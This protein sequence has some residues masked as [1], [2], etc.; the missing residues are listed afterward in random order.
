MSVESACR[1]CVVP[2]MT[3]IIAGVSLPRVP[4]GGYCSQVFEIG[5]KIGAIFQFFS[6]SVA[7]ES[8]MHNPQ[9]R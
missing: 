3:Q 7:P 2:D 6:S 5:L 1:H 9:S 8:T 4:R